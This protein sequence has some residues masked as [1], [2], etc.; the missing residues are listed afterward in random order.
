[1]N[2]GIGQPISRLD[3]RAKVTGAARYTADTQIADIA[4]A[5]MVPGTIPK[6]TI[7][8]RPRRRRVPAFSASSLIAMLRD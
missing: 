7:W 4:F 3:G 2:D 6:G 5:V 8:R 1:M